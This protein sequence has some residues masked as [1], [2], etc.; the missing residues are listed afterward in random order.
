[1]FFNELCPNC[2]CVNAHHLFEKFSTLKK[3][4]VIIWLIEKERFYSRYYLKSYYFF[5][6]TT[7]CIPIGKNFSKR[8]NG[9]LIAFKNTKCQNLLSIL[10]DQ[11]I[12]CCSILPNHHKVKASNVPYLWWSIIFHLSLLNSTWKLFSEKSVKCL[13]LCH[14]CQYCSCFLALI[15]L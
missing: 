8:K 6:I 3:V 9:K 14:P 12:C 5:S 10:S 13:G 15:L 7:S 4:L 2:I 1:M 11:F